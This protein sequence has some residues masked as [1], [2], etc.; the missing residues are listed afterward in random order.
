[1]NTSKLVSCPSPLSVSVS[2]YLSVSVSLCVC[3]CLSASASLSSS[4]LSLNV[5]IDQRGG[6]KR[7]K[8]KT[9]HASCTMCQC[10]QLLADTFNAWSN[11]LIFFFLSYPLHCCFKTLSKIIF[12]LRFI[13]LAAKSEGCL[14]YTSPRPRDA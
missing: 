5:S 14:L 10:S 13:S 8:K 12:L 2:L 6:R 1:M 3:L 4:Y 11:R 7:K 9:M